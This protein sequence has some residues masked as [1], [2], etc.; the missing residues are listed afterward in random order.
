MFV[1]NPRLPKCFQVWLASFF[2]EIHHITF[3]AGKVD[4]FCNTDLIGECLNW[5]ATSTWLQ[6]L[7][8][9]DE[10]G[11][12]QCMCWAQDA[13][14]HDRS[15]PDEEPSAHSNE[16]L[17]ICHFT[18]VIWLTC[19]LLWLLDN[20][21]SFSYPRGSL[22]LPSPVSARCSSALDS[23]LRLAGAVIVG[24]L[25]V[26]RSERRLVLGRDAPVVRARPSCASE[27]RKCKPQAYEFTYSTTTHPAH[28]SS[29][30]WAWT[31]HGRATGGPCGRSSC[32]RARGFAASYRQ[33]DGRWGGEGCWRLD[34]DLSSGAQ[35]EL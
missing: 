25:A 8:G 15:L 12:M 23:L 2:L 18:S 1:L 9:T 17:F 20:T 31:R 28:L 6:R 16:H 35:I 26:E 5:R 27:Q 10:V 32:S 33:S 14:L 22:L 21:H 30:L 19:T 29:C 13:L 11:S 34:L 24:V 3:Q 4:E 7:D